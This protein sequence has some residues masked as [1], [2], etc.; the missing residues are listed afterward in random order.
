VLVSLALHTSLTFAL[1][2]IYIG[3]LGVTAILVWQITDDGDG[4]PYEGWAL[5]AIYLVLAIIT[6][7][8]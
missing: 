6:L 4:H 2:P 3:A 1:P 8:E 5:I 7:Y